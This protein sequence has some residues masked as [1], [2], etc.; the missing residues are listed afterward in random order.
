MDGP[1]KNYLNSKMKFKYF[2]KS[3]KIIQLSNLI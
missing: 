3:A 1:L 2:Y